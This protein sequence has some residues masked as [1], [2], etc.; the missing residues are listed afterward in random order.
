MLS[1][2]VDFLFCRYVHILKSYQKLNTVKLTSCR[3]LF[4]IGGKIL[5]LLI[6]IRPSLEI[7]YNDSITVGLAPVS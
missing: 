7:L 1:T 2:G 3:E 4:G 5:T 6:V